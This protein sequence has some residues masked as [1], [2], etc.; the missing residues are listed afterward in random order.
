MRLCEVMRLRDVL[1]ALPNEVW[2]PSFKELVTAICA[3]PH[4]TNN[5]CIC[6]P[7]KVEPSQIC[8]A[9]HT[10]VDIQQHCSDTLRLPARCLEVS[11]KIC[12]YTALCA[13]RIALR[14]SQKAKQ[15]NTSYC[16]DVQRPSQESLSP[17]VKLWKFDGSRGQRL[18]ILGVSKEAYGQVQ[19]YGACFQ[20]RLVQLFEAL[21]PA[22]QGMQ[23][24][25]WQRVDRQRLCVSPTL[26]ATSR[27]DANKGRLARIFRLLKG[28]VPPQGVR[29]VPPAGTTGGDKE[30]VGGPTSANLHRWQCRPLRFFCKHRS[31]GHT[32]AR[33]LQPVKGQE[34]QAKATSKSSY[35]Y[36]HS[37]KRSSK[38]MKPP[39]MIA[40]GTQDK[41][42]FPLCSHKQWR[43]K[44]QPLPPGRTCQLGNLG[45]WFECC[46]ELGDK[47]N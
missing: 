47:P 13:G 46:S 5:I 10:Y 25:G 26:S 20:R 38:N 1:P 42:L 19:S 9:T 15:I 34:C 36:I 2:L 43:S 16:C 11:L 30:G 14:R 45:T 35:M 12:N 40:P 24:Q 41:R 39:L 18:R 17:T 7:S 33:G 44:P 32:P 4:C 8:P 31:Q 21:C 3:Q 6:S 28:S 22:A 23:L 37:H 27:C 29:M